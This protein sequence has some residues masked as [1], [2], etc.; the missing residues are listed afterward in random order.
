[1]PSLYSQ[2][3]TRCLCIVCG[4]LLAALRLHVTLPLEHHR[5]G[6]EPP[7]AHQSSEA[8]STVREQRRDLD[9]IWWGR[10]HLARISHIVTGIDSANY[11]A[12]GYYGLC[13]N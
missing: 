4:R 9:E 13:V 6:I 3:L 2:P 5:P 1:M 8:F 12:S 11:D 7:T 10:L